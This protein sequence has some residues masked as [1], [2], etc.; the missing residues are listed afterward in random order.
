[1]DT[2]G[3]VSRFAPMHF[4][5]KGFWKRGWKFI[6]TDVILDLTV[7]TVA[8]SLLS[9]DIRCCCAN[10]TMWAGSH[11]FRCVTSKKLVSSSLS[12]LVY[13]TLPCLLSVWS[14]RRWRRPQGMSVRILMISGLLFCFVSFRSCNAFILTQ[15]SDF[16]GVPG[17]EMILSSFVLSR[18]AFVLSIVGF[19]ATNKRLTNPII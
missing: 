5:K 10:C 11:C 8:L 3:F 7:V 18:D 13:A 16:Y 19:V 9:N 15:K 12:L 14:F 17:E 1:M 2:L 6:H 4:L